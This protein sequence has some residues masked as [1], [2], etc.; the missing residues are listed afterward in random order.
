MKNHT[1]LI[2]YIQLNFSNPANISTL[3]G[4]PDKLYVNFIGAELFFK[5]K[6]TNLTLKGNDRFM[7]TYLIQ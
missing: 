7:Y 4:N 3:V 5:T 1:D 2:I 6:A